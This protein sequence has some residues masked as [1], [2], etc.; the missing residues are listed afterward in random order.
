MPKS[1]FLVICL[2]SAIMCVTRHVAGS[3]RKSCAL[4]LGQ[5]R[6]KE[7]NNT[8]ENLPRCL[9]A[10]ARVIITP[11]RDLMPISKVNYL[12]SRAKTY[13]TSKGQA[14]HGNIVVSPVNLHAKLALRKRENCFQL[15]QEQCCFSTQILFSKHLTIAQPFKRG[16]SCVHE[17]IHV[18]L[19]T[20]CTRGS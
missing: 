8:T 17:G 7:K 20:G 3:Y 19:A 6:H 14:K 1:C 9:T 4:P 16:P 12:L 13:I 10:R 15:R 11:Q 18:P 5:S 2:A